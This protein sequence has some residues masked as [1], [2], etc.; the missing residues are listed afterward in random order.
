M[1]PHCQK[2]EK[3]SFDGSLADWLQTQPGLLPL[4]RVASL[5]RKAADA[6]QEV[7]NQQKVYQDVNPCNF[8]L[9]VQGEHAERL[10]LKL[11][12]LDAQAHAALKFSGGYS[13]NSL[14]AYMAHEQW[15]GQVVPA[16]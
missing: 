1:S 2:G 10:D 14:S 3:M 8:L 12:D 16:S 13:A 4:Q 5:V 9:H 7:H 15:L 6:L 11:V